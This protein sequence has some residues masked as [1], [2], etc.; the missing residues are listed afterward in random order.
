MAFPKKFKILVRS[1]LEE[2]GFLKTYPL[3]YDISLS[4]RFVEYAFVLQNIDEGKLKVLDVG[5][6]GTLFPIMLA[7]LGYN[8]VGIDL[9]SYGYTHPHFKFVKGDI[10]EAKK[11][12]NLDSNIEETKNRIPE[13]LDGIGKKRYL[14]EAKKAVRRENF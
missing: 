11:K 10:L 2:A 7:S 3:L 4:E 13:V 12:R 5:C 6:H 8:V 1:K 14:F 9:K